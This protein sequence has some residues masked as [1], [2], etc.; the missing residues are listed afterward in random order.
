[1][2]H[3][4]AAYPA[5]GTRDG[6]GYVYERRRGVRRMG[7]IFAS[8]NLNHLFVP[9]RSGRHTSLSLACTTTICVL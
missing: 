8:S 7:I 9:L 3:A 4:R 5:M 1:M 6:C 2:E